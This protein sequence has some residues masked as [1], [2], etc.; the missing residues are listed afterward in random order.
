MQRK[1]KTNAGPGWEAK[2]SESEVNRLRARLH[3]LEV[4]YEQTRLQNDQLT[5]TLRLIEDARDRYVYLY[6]FSPHAYITLDGYGVIEEINLNGTTLL[7]RDRKAAVGT[8]MSVFLVRDDC[9]KFLDH[10]RRCRGGDARVVSVVSFKDVG[11]GPRLVQ[12]A[13]M[14]SQP[15]ESAPVSYLT[16]ITDLTEREKAQKALAESQERLQMAQ[17]AAGAGVWDWDLANNRGEWSPEHYTVLGL[18]PGETPLSYDL[19]LRSIH[20]EDRTSA[21]QAW[22]SIPH[23]QREQFEFNY[24]IITAQDEVRWVVSKG[25]L[26]RNEAGKPVRMIGITIDVT[27]LKRAGHRLQELN[28]E[29]IQRTM[30]AE[31]RATELRKLAGEVTRAEHRE[32]RRVAHVIHDHLQQLLVAATMR[33]RTIDWQNH[34]LEQRKQTVQRAV[35]LLKQSIEEARSLTVELSPPV[36]QDRGLGPALEWLARHT[37]EK[38]ALPIE[39]EVQPGSEPD[40]VDLRAFLF[41]CV[42]ELLFNVSKHSGATRAVVTLAPLGDAK[43]QIVVSDNGK[44]FDPSLLEV[45]GVAADH[46]GIFSIRERL[47]LLGGLLEIQSAPG[48]GTRVTLVSPRQSLDLRG[49]P[50]PAALPAVD[51]AAGT[52]AGAAESDGSKIRVLL[53]DDHEILRQGLAVVLHEEPDIELVG[54]ASDGQM[55][56]EMA[57]QLRPDVVVMDISM[58]R[59]NGI[60]AT[61]QLSSEMP[62]IKIIGLSMHEERDMAVA[63]R[64]AG[65]AAYLTKDA[66]S[67]L[68][69]DAIRRHSPL[70]AAKPSLHAQPG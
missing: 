59:L 22:L 28:E 11:E 26:I 17:S 64:E 23:T 31:Q 68:L 15:V 61:R 45:E 47:K 69:V 60:E 13:S 54:E 6:D 33:L 52:A 3:D 30:E 14:P 56:V 51:A 1:R 5:T 27:E 20:P 25:R 66:P 12:L 53:A 42:R 10:M 63:M 39:I 55:A 34:S 7:G 67:D 9:R 29:L 43:V 41:Q 49:K 16:A 65:A 35:D 32:R 24:R 57:R 19:W 36:L 18:K 38:H 44:G 4:L 2:G 50:A 62:E 46:F 58:P 48:Q 40:S 21:A 70:A 37:Q 8:P